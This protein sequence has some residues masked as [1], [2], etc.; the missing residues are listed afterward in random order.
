MTARDRELVRQ[1]NART[2]KL[3][4]SLRAAY[5]SAIEELRRRVGTEEVLVRI[6]RLELDR[7][8]TEPM[9]ERAF[10]RMRAELRREA[11]VAF[12]FEIPGLRAAASSAGATSPAAVSAAFAPG[13]SISFNVLNPRVATALS[14]LDRNILRAVQDDLKGV[15]VDH[16]QAALAAGVPTSQAARSLRD[17]IGLTPT[18]AKHVRNFRD[19]LERAGRLSPGEK[20]PLEYGLRDR[21]FDRTVRKAL[22]GKEALT[23]AQV[24][25]MVEAYRAKYV[26]WHGNTVARTAV[27]NAFTQGQKA[28]IGSAADSGLMPANRMTKRWV[29]VGDARVRPEH[30]E[31]D[32][33]TVPLDGLFSNGLDVPNEWNCR[34][35]IRY[36][37][38]P[39]ATPV[40]PRRGAVPAAPAPNAAPAPAPRPRTVPRRAPGPAAAAPTP[41]PAPAPAPGPYQ[42][43][44]GPGR[45]R[46]LDDSIRTA[47][48]RIRNE[49][50]E[51]AHVV[52]ADGS[53]L[54]AKGGT[55]SQVAFTTAEVQLMKNATLTHNHPAGSWGFS[56]ADVNIAIAADMAEM[57]SVTRDRQVSSLLR[58]PGGWGVSPT[59][60]VRVFNETSR[61]IASAIG[62]LVQAGRIT[63]AEAQ[64]RHF[65]DVAERLAGRF[66]WTYSSTFHD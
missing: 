63:V 26:A 10:L 2:K 49:A 12:R 34:C 48:R 28:A 43:P 46:A 38:T 52:A 53:V 40:R 30:V 23:P 11:E 21:R 18:Q 41:A 14:N 51:E 27:L 56:D 16:L 57:R 7:V 45:S 15:V 35:R 3:E 17:V 31:M 55:K 19:R 36:E 6:A 50:I 62:P 20:S 9:L 60:A 44:W 4:P 25:R 24:D 33:E 32:G 22:A 39:L 8:I 37:L 65:R 1:I 5:F 61:Q 42:S 59:E 66:G 13:G 54:L 58:P 29:T 47:E 64:Q